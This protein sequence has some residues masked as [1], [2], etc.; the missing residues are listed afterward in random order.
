MGMQSECSGKVY[1]VSDVLLDICTS[2]GTFSK[3]YIE[4]VRLLLMTS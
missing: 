1:I 3:F 4:Y 2:A